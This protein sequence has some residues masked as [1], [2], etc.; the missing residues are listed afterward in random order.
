MKYVVDSNV[1]AK[2]VLPELDSDSARLLRDGFSKGTHNLVAPDIFPIEVG[3]ALTRAERQRRI[4][5]SESL[6]LWVDVMTTPPQ[7]VSSL[8][9]MPRALVLSS[10]ARI[11]VYDCLYVALAERE[12]TR[13]VTAGQRLLATFP[14][15]AIALDALP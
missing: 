10:Q 9:L 11:G 8:P 2:W 7:F 3:H 13:V 4:S 14:A 15:F 12:L 6:N 5:Q 1:A